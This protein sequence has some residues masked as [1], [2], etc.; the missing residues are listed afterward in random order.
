M[1]VDLSLSPVQSRAAA[2]ALAL[3]PVALLAF[4]GVALVRD[5]SLHHAA[6]ERLLTERETDRQAI[7]DEPLLAGKIAE[8]RSTVGGAPLFY[9]HSQ[10]S[11]A[12]VRMESAITAIA[13]RNKAAQFHCNVEFRDLGESQPQEL[14]A[15]VTLHADITALTHILYDLRQAKPLLFVDSLSVK[16]DAPPGAA[17]TAPNELQVEMTILGYLQEE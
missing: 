11:D 4:A 10:S 8:M 2:V 13:S 16:S 1:I 17:L 3:V 15:T 6:V 12:A 9:I 5:R 7:G 14:R